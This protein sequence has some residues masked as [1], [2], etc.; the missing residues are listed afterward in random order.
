MWAGLGTDG[1]GRARLSGLI[2]IAPHHHA[3]DHVHTSK[4][5]GVRM[6]IKALLPDS[7]FADGGHVAPAETYGAC[8][9]IHI[10]KSNGDSIWIGTYTGLW[11]SQDGGA[12]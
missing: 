2:R 6:L 5:I 4:P 7:S 9:A 10:M 3:L 1:V 12:T 11:E 8:R